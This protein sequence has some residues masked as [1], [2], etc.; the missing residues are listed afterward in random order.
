MLKVIV[1]DTVSGESNEFSTDALVT[2]WKDGDCA[3]AD[4]YPSGISDELTCDLVIGAY[5][6]LLCDMYGKG[7]GE[8]FDC[9]NEKYAKNALRETLKEVL[10]NL[11]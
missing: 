5:Y 2:L 9:V 1:V 4:I 11:D 8:L 6:A 3:N 7:K 10:K